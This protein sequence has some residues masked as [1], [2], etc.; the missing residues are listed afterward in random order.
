MLWIVRPLPV[1]FGKW[2]H[3]HRRRFAI[4][5]LLKVPESYYI[6]IGGFGYIYLNI[7]S[8]DSYVLMRPHCTYVQ[9]IC[10]KITAIISITLMTDLC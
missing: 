4:L 10:S 2:L 8:L 3:F 9:N 1:V 5:I 6:K 7:K